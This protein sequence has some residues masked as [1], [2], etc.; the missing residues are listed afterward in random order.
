MNILILSNAPWSTSGYG[1]QAALLARRL[2]AA[3]H[4]VGFSA[5]FGLHGAIRGWEG[6][7]VYPA[8]HTGF[9]KV[10][11]PYHVDHFGQ[12]EPVQV[13]TL[14]DLWVLTHPK[15]GDPALFDG[16]NLAS[17]MPVDHYPLPLTI[18]HALQHIK[19]RAIAMSRFGQETLAESGVNSMYVPHSIETSVYQPYPDSRDELRAAMGVP[20]DAFLIGMVANNQGNS[21]VRKGFPQLLQAFA[22][23]E[24]THPDSYLYLHTDLRGSLDGIN[25]NTCAYAAGV[26]DEK[27]KAIDQAKYQMGLVPPEAMARI[28]SLLDVLAM[29]SLG[30]GFGIP[31]IEAQACGVP[32]ISTDWTAMPELVGAGWKV[33]GDRWYDQAHGSYFMCPSVYEITEALEHAYEAREDQQL[34]ERARSFA[35]QYDSDRVFTEHW[36]PTLDALSRP[37]EVGPLKPNRAARRAKQKT[38]A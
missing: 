25:L 10:M 7:P 9:N 35:L 16:L 15:Y 19:T 32:V 38:A 33:Q 3:G 1:T 8:D 11:L 18:I 12:G 21:P 22:E 13:L 4:R 26:P 20:L 28:Y 37:H 27:I 34:K 29:P 2:A 17:W 14:I 6:M 5:Q 30:E 23:F 24:R 36:Q 31:A